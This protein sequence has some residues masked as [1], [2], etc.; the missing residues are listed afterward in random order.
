MVQVDRLNG[1]ANQAGLRSAGDIASD[2]DRRSGLPKAATDKAQ[3]EPREAAALL[4]ERKGQTGLVSAE[5]V[6]I[7][8]DI[9]RAVQRD[10]RGA[11]VAASRLVTLLT[12]STAVE[13]AHIR[14][15][16][17]PWQKRKVD[18]FVREH[19]QREITVKDL[20]S[21]I[22]ISVSHFYRAFKETHGETPR[23]YVTSLRL[24]LAQELMLRTD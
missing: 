23:S 6:Q 3:P 21:E 14:G 10:P 24:E 16:L 8:H 9:C 20:A 19:I 13:S 11:R 7:A 18:E 15:G 17:A 4:S 12:Q 22:S 5:V 1:G 2:A